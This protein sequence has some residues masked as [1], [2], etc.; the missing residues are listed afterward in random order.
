[1]VALN[2][3]EDRGWRMTKPKKGFGS[4]QTRTMLEAT[5]LGGCFKRAI[6]LQKV[7]LLDPVLF[8]MQEASEK[9]SVGQKC[10][11]IAECNAVQ[12]PKS[13]VVGPNFDI[14]SYLLLAGHNYFH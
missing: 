3:R 14:I 10:L 2:H 4:G 5:H 6:F 13:V 8:H 1:M 11:W 9:V 7:P 12:V